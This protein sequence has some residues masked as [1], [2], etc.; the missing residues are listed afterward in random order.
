MENEG[1]TA[2]ESQMLADDALRRSRNYDSL[3]RLTGAIKNLTAAIERKFPD[4]KLQAIINKM[5][6]PPDIESTDGLH[7]ICDNLV[8]IKEYADTGKQ[9]ISNQGQALDGFSELAYYRDLVEQ[10]KKILD[11]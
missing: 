6:G 5:G 1:K 8:K 10:L 7:L 4:H 2:T 11:K 9:L 3:D